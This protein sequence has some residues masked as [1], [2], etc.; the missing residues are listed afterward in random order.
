MLHHIRQSTGAVAVLVHGCVAVP[1]QV[2]V[3]LWLQH[4]LLVQSVSVGTGLVAVH[5]SVF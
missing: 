3:V 5:S 2:A 4:G 1:C